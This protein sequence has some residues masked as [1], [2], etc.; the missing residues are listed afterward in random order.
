MPLTHG[1]LEEEVSTAVDVASPV[2]YVFPTTIVEGAIREIDTVITS[3]VST[4]GTLETMTMTAR[5][6]LKKIAKGKETMKMI[7]AVM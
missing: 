1:A 5:K 3:I 4:I 2:D 7:K 6:S